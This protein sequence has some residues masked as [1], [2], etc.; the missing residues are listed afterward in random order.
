MGKRDQ[1][2]GEKVRNKAK[3]HKIFE[4]EWKPAAEQDRIECT[5]PLLRK[6]CNI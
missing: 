6:V 4:W 5:L 1:E 2:V 3:G